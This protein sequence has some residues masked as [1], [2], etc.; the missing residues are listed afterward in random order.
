MNAVWYGSASTRYDLRNCTMS[1]PHVQLTCLSSP[2]AGTGYNLQ[3]SVMY[4]ASGLS[5]EVL[6]YRP[7]SLAAVAPTVCSARP[8]LCARWLWTF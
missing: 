7:P 4:Q 8:W 3:V 5:T 2:G 1:M 6:S